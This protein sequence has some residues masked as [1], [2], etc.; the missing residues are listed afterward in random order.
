MKNNKVCLYSLLSPKFSISGDEDVSL[1]PGMGTGEWG[2]IFHME[3]LFPA[4]RRTKEV[5]NVLLA[6]AVP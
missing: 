3:N 2:G 1:P 4:F 6:L 5:Q